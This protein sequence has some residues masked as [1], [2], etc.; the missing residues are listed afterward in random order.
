M[1]LV[2][3]HTQTLSSALMAV[4]SPRILLVGYSGASLQYARQTVSIA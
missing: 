3:F 1:L 2:A 4:D